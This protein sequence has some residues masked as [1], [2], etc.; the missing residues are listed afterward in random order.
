MTV[1]LLFTFPSSAY[2]VDIQLPG[3]PTSLLYTSE[4]MYASPSACDFLDQ[5]AA[6]LNMVTQDD[7]SVFDTR[8][9]VDGGANRHV[10]DIPSH[11]KNFKSIA[12]L[13]HV[14]KKGAAM[15]AIGVG[16]VDLHCVDNMGNPC[17]VPL[18]DV[19][20]IPEAKKSLVS[21][22]MLRNKGINVY[23]P[24]PIRSFL[25]EFIS[26]DAIVSQEVQVGNIFRFNV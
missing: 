11:F 18:K 23:I 25:L 3:G 5:R 9:C 7:T 14:A 13:V 10:H 1:I 16:D 26:H 15:Q 12:I 6:G 8:W 24:A 22:S 17:I 21:V 4:Y 20:C 19:L 2:S